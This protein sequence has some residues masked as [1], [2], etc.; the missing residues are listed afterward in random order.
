MGRFINADNYPSTGQ[1]I[2]GNNM[3]AYCNN[4]PVIYRDSSGNAL[5]TVIDVI[6]L[7]SSIVAVAQNPNDPWAWVGLAGDLVDVAIPFVGGIGETVK[8]TS[9]LFKAADNFDDVHD[10]VKA[11]DFS[12]AACFVAGTTVL[13]AGGHVAIENIHAGDYV[14]A[15]DEETGEVALKQVVETYV[16]E[17]SE[18]IHVFVNGEEIITTP[19][20]PFYSPVKGWT[21]AAK[22]RAGDILVLVNGEYVVV[23]KV[24]HEILETPI[25]VYN[26]QVEDFHTYYVTTSGILVHNSCKMP[27]NFSPAGAGRHGAFNQAKR[28]LGIPVSKQPVVLPNID[29]RGNIVPGRVYDFDGIQIRDDVVGHSFNDGGY[30]PPHFNTPDGRHYFY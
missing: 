10:T 7:F 1:D 3:F 4:N 16:N 8:A 23:E 19:T 6:S 15:W 26:F 28:D 12:G 21:E 13:A 2:L 24:L 11:I 27:E 20:H 5:D 22:L 9:T 17:S 29:R 14:W 30:L 18:L 25:T